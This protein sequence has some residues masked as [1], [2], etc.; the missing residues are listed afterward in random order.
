MANP[1]RS[2]VNELTN[3][4]NN[5]NDVA[6][7]NLEISNESMH[8]NNSDDKSANTTKAEENKMKDA[9]TNNGPTAKTTTT[10]A[11]STEPATK[12][13]EASCPE[14]V[15]LSVGKTMREYPFKYKK[16]NN[17]NI[18]T[19]Y[20]TVKEGNTWNTIPITACSFGEH[21]TLMVA[22]DERGNIFGFDML[23]KRYW[24]ITAVIAKACVITPWL[25]FNAYLV[26][27][28]LGQLFLLDL[29][30]SVVKKALPL[31][32]VPIKAISFLG[33]PLQNHRLVL[34]Q[35]GHEAVLI[36]LKKFTVLHKLKFDD[37]KAKLKFAC[38]LPRTEQ[39]FTLLKNNC[40]NVWSKVTL[41]S[42]RI[43]NPIKM[44]DRKLHMKGTAALTSDIAICDDYETIGNVYPDSKKVDDSK[45]LVIGFCYH[46][47]NGLIC[48]STLDKYLLII[49]MY[50][51]ELQ[52]ICRLRDTV[53]GEC[54][55]LPHAKDILICGVTNDFGQVVIIDCRKKDSKLRIQAGQAEHLTV[56]N[57]GKL[58]TIINRNGVVNIWS[59]AKIYESLK[60]QEECVQLLQVAFKQNCPIPIGP[61]ENAK[62]ARAAERRCIDKDVRKLLSR[63][64]LLNILH[65]YRWFPLKYRTLI[66]CA[67]LQLPYN[68]RAFHNLLKLGIPPMVKQRAQH[69][70]MRNETLKRAL[71][72]VWSCLARWC[73]VFAHSKF[74]P[75]LI[76]PFVK[77]LPR[78]ALVVF[79]ICATLIM[80]HFQLC[81]EFHP[82]E[83]NNYLGLCENILQHYAPELCTFYASMHVGPE[84]Y[85]WPLL[86]TCFS[87]VF[88]EKQWL[89]LWDNILG[90][91]SYFPIFIAVSFNMQ[92]CE[93]T[94]Y[95]T[96][97][98]T[99]VDCFRG[100]CTLDACMVV[101]NAC[102]L[103]AKCPPTLHPKRYMKEFVGLPRNVY[104]KFLNYPREWLAKH[105]EDIEA[106]QKEQRT[107]DAR[108]RQLELEEI[109][110]MQRL[111]SGLRNEEHANQ[112]KKMEKLYQDSLKRE[113][114]RL[115]CQRKV[116]MLYQKEVRNRK[117]EVAA[118]MQESEQRQQA[119]KM[120][121]DLELLMQSIECERT[122]NDA[123]L[124]IAEE[125]IRN[126][127]IELYLQKCLKAPRHSSLRVK[128]HD[129]MLRLCEERRLLK[130]QLHEISNLEKPALNA[131]SSADKSKLDTIEEKI[132]EIQ[133][134]FNEILNS[135]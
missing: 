92:M 52:H 95:L 12:Y 122:R 86:Y 74:L 123:D 8:K 35:A 10:A 87:E 83:P 54:V 80:N 55:F 16:T 100:P 28:K 47:G 88:L 43:F 113:E 32:K 106:V 24:Q 31:A 118:Q 104:P 127:D 94:M 22:I 133:R 129:D 112:M 51:F 90:A 78:N 114:E 56:S 89:Y 103:M 13:D 65:E 101:K 93:E 30:K 121:K 135:K 120:E 134:E 82:L 44:R 45:G 7:N 14:N 62:A 132:E 97:K 130:Q 60:S 73:P 29:D 117:A 37:A 76:F 39:I 34:V 96:D 99:I 41:K 2:E 50:T 69:L 5:L 70:K 128:Y 107:I 36:N 75:E 59:V 71:V 21:C 115:A 19:V 66:W 119:L 25:E 84:H 27:T 81:F 111:E 105:E 61:A 109:K 11:V 85:A 6:L 126:Q 1:A 67:L 124:L 110:L 3:E 40:I 33:H 42:L 48:L 72:R 64:R 20:H 15:Q 116:L 108:I 125:E 91:A 131:P 68:R 98:P 4:Q 46:S 57:D 77:L 63:D 53:I 102:V 9:G 38:Y 17:G 23:H 79:E 58:L 49:N 26:G 18:L